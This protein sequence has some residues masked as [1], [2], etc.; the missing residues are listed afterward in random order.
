MHFVQEKEFPEA[1]S[2]QLA[3]NTGLSEMSARRL[4]KKDR[5]SMSKLNPIIEDGLL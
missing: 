3:L 5:A 4:M 2:L 1:R